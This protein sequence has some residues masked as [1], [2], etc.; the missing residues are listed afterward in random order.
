MTRKA[1]IFGRGSMGKAVARGLEKLG[2][3]VHTA[4]IVESDDEFLKRGN[5]DV[6]LSIPS[7]EAEQAKPTAAAEGGDDDVIEILTPG[8]NANAADKDVFEGFDWVS[9]RQEDPH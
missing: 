5:G 2:L 4:D 3:E 9:P 8:K 7:D 6:A 1:L